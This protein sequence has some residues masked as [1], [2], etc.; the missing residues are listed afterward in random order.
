MQR[1]NFPTG[2]KEY[3][4]CYTEWIDYTQVSHIGRQLSIQIPC[5]VAWVHGCVLAFSP[6]LTHTSYCQSSCVVAVKNVQSGMTAFYTEED[7]FR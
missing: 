5:K 7:L 2:S 4:I 1:L 3:I 6:E